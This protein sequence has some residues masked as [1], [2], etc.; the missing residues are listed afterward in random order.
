MPNMVSKQDQLKLKSFLAKESEL[1]A[2]SR[3]IRTE[4]L[5]KPKNIDSKTN[6][7][8][9]VFKQARAS[10]VKLP[11]ATHDLCSL[12]LCYFPGD[13]ASLRLKGEA[14]AALKQNDE[15][16]RIWRD[17][18]HSGNAK[19]SQKATELIADNLA[20]RAKIISNK[21]STKAALSFFIKQHLMLHLAPSLNKEIS[22]I[23]I[24]ANK[25][26]SESCDHELQKHQL[27]LILNTLVIEHLENHWRD[28]C[29][30]TE[31]AAAQKPGA[32]RKTA[33]KAG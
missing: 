25:L 20:A 16:I 1:I 12:I 5:P 8:S 22:K 23:L 3:C 19:I 4:F 24:K 14:L 33:Q 9:L 32:I 13:L 27:Q 28:K 10:L 26:P 31:T 6:I 11:E 18:V 17:L 29:R 15:A 21:R 2:I 30:L 7:K